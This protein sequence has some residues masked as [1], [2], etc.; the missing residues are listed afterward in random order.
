MATSH[1]AQSAANWILGVGDRHL[2]NAL[3]LTQTG[4]LFHFIFIY[5]FISIDY[6][7]DIVGIDFGMAFGCATSRLPVPELVP[8]RLTPQFQNLIPGLA[9]NGKP[10]VNFLVHSLLIRFDACQGPIRDGMIHT[11]QVA[12]TETGPLMAAMSIFVSE[13][14]LEWIR[15][16]TATIQSADFTPQQAI[17]RARDIL[18]GA[19]PAEITCRDLAKNPEC[20]QFLG[21]IMNA[22]RGI[23]PP[24]TDAHCAKRKR[25]NPPYRSSL[26][27]DGLTVEQQVFHSFIGYYLFIQITFWFSFI[28]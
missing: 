24:S 25:D 22:V 4:Q 16:S 28:D 5:S 14:T 15:T 26:P 2:S 17:G 18:D 27:P 8:C 10:N 23:T 9:L 12:R 7:G 11:L 21:E 13:P 3:V 20:R 1:G 6:L 19:H